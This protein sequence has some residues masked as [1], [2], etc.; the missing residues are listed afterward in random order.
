MDAIDASED[1]GV[2]IPCDP[3]LPRGAPG[4]GQRR[5][6]EVHQ[7]DPDA[8]EQKPGAERP[9]LGHRPADQGDGDH[10]EGEL[11]GHPDDGG[12]RPESTEHE[13]VDSAELT[14]L[15]QLTEPEE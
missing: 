8:T 6:R 7:G 4:A 2:W 14:H 15:R 5:P 13:G 9:P 1:A 10:R 12:Y 11:E 3:G